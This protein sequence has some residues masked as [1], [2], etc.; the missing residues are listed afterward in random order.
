MLKNLR[1]PK[2]LV[3]PASALA[4]QEAVVAIA[5]LVNHVVIAMTMTADGPFED[6]ADEQKEGSPPRIFRIKAQVSHQETNMAGGLEFRCV[7]KKL[8]TSTWVVD[9]IT[10]NG[11]GDIY[12]KIEDHPLF[13]RKLESMKV[14]ARKEI[15]RRLHEQTPD[16]AGEIVARLHPKPQ[17]VPNDED[18]SF[19]FVYRGEYP[20]DP[21]A[22]DGIR[23]WFFK[24]TLLELPDGQ[25]VPIDARGKTSLPSREKV[26]F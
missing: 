12:L 1:K 22:P 5:E 9:E 10:V 2:R 20:D 19:T 16:D 11:P 18:G 17:I 4:A 7:T 6:D 23:P 3:T 25:V 13:R 14:E 8:A 15:Y 21:Q 26:V 24:V